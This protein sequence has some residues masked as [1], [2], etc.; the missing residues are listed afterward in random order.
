MFG[1]VEIAVSKNTFGM[2][3]TF[4]HCTSRGA[5]VH[6]QELFK[7]AKA[8]MMSKTTNS[9]DI[10]GSSVP[11]TQSVHC[12]STSAIIEGKVLA[13]SITRKDFMRMLLYNFDSFQGNVCSKEGA[14]LLAVL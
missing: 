10:P 2:N 14:L 1:L 3:K 12:A 4:E 6:H 9:T 5:A 11:S 8:M 13:K 7:W